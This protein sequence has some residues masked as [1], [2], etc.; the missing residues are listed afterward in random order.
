METIS[1]RV[2]IRGKTGRS[3][4][5]SAEELSGPEDQLLQWHEGKSR[6]GGLKHWPGGLWEGLSAVGP[7]HLCTSLP[8]V[9]GVQSPDRCLP[10][11]YLWFVVRDTER[12]DISKAELAYLLLT[13][14]RQLP[15]AQ[16]PLLSHCPQQVHTSV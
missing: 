3:T 15:P 2:V 8:Y 12:Q 14:K 16:V 11:L 13:G 5:S 1:S 10:R 6:P 9:P 7:E 4:L